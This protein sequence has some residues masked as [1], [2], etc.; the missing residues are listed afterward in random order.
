M[1]KDK[2]AKLKTTAEANKEMTENTEAVAEE[3]ETQAEEAATEGEIET[4]EETIARLEAEL[5]E[6]R[7]K[8]D[9]LTDQMQRMAADFQNTRRRQERQLQMSIERATEALIDKLLPVLDDFEMA[10]QNIPEESREDNAAWIAGFQQIYRKLF[11][12][13]EEEGLKAIA[14]EGEFNPNLHEAISHEPNE[15]VESGHII[16]TLRKGY[17][18]KERV[19]RPALV[20]VAQ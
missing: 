18:H 12:I 9:E 14:S 2:E 11:T 7:A 5:A 15:E 19:L 6:T 3:V 16:E 17:E 10:F 1:G 20:R 8:L 13:L 4:P